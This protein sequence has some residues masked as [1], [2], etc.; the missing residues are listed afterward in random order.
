M[1]N[2]VEGSCC[3]KMHLDIHQMADQW[4]KLYPWI[5]GWGDKI[6]TLMSEN[7]SGWK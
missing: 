4:K 3:A 7:V 6:W 5:T 1:D 2:I